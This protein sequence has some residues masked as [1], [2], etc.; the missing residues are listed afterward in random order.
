[1]TLG[2]KKN[3]QKEPVSAVENS[4]IHTSAPLLIAGDIVFPGE[5]SVHLLA[6]AP[7]GASLG[8]SR[9]EQADHDK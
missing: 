2:F 9:R 7:G 3:R 4:F 8:A 1:M 5:R 6:A